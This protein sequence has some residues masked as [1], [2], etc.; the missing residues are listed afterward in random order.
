MVVWTFDILL[1]PTTHTPNWYEAVWGMCGGL[2]IRYIVGSH[3]TYSQII[4]LSPQQA[5]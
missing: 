4:L 3:Y 2:D 1:D 5:C